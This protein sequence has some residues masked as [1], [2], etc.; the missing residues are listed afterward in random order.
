VP[1]Q[2]AY[3]TPE[4]RNAALAIVEHFASGPVEAVLLTNSCARGRATPDSCLDMAVL[5][6]PGLP[7]ADR[8]GLD[9]SWEAY[10]E[11]DEVFRTLRGAGQY[12]EVHL[13][14]VEGA[15]APEPRDEAAG[16]DGFELE[17]GN[18]LVYSQPLLVHGDYLDQ[19]K[20]Q[21]LPYYAESLRRERLEMVRWYC[22]NN[23]RH[24]PGYVARGLH[25][26]AFDRL[27]NAYRE[28]LQALFMARRTYPIAYNKWIREQV[29]DI[30]VLPDLYSQL[31]HLF[32][33]RHFEGAE[34]TERGE[35]V[36]RLLETYAPAP[37]A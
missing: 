28:F 20:Q 3:P 10:Y 26:Q 25:F 11:T 13:N 19:L 34:L 24:I 22:L 14:I 35:A 36:E 6:R 2:A 33:I 4:H 31:T 17:I 27:Y 21:W 9:Q 12:S 8:L 18:L 37:D 5:I 29:V 16:P 15:F 30:L 7:R 1:W 23:L 32:E